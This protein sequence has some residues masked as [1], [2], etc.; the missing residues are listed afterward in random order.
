MTDDTRKLLILDLDET[1]IF[2]IETP[3]KRDAD[4]RVGR[5][6]VYRRPFLLDFLA[7]SLERFTVAVWT[8]SS[9]DYAAAVVTAI[10]PE[11]TRLAFVWAADRCS[12]RYC[13]D[14]GS[15]YTRKP[16]I[17]VH[18]RLGYAREQIVVVDDTPRKWEQSYGNVVTVL[19]FEGAPND[20]EL[21]LLSAYLNHLRYVPNVRTVEKRRWRS[22]ASAL[23][24][25]SPERHTIE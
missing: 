17:K 11:P 8:S 24:A 1:L 7:E 15:Y 3:L 12:T 14:D 6:H 21:P 25:P 16:L 9:P 18:R 4:F 13:P 23:L 20:T 19:P 22:E 5:Y 2:A 10:F